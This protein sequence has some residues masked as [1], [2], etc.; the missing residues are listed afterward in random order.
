MSTAAFK[1]TAYAA[2][3]LGLTLFIVLIVRNDLA[4]IGRA[5]ALGGWPLFWLLPYRLI[6]FGLYA[7]AWEDRKSVV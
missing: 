2:G 1:R 6:F 4:R 3:V 7:L 5:L